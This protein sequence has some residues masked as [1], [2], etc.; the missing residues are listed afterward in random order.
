MP[1]RKLAAFTYIR[2]YVNYAASLRAAII[3]KSIAKRKNKCFNI[4]IYHLRK[5]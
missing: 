4:T 1:L 5:D 2:K 3:Y